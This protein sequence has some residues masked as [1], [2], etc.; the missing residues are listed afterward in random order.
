MNAKSI[1]LYE[2]NTSNIHENFLCEYTGTL[3][4]HLNIYYAYSY[5]YLGTNFVFFIII[6]LCIDIY[7]IIFPI[8][9]NSKISLCI[10]HFQ[11]PIVNTYQ[12]I[13]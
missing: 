6:S 1:Y 9:R 4:K 3:S 11:A 2:N 13:L 5:L 8:V 7:S 12:Q 10:Y